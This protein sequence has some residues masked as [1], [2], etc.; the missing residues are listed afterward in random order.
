[1]FNL[2]ALI[3]IVSTLSLT[4]AP[5]I[6][7]AENIANVDEHTIVINE[8]QLNDDLNIYDFSMSIENNEINGNIEIFHGD[9]TY[10]YSELSYIVFNWSVNIEYFYDVQLQRFNG[11]NVWGWLEN[12]NREEKCFYN[13]DLNLNMLNGRQYSTLQTNLLWNFGV[14]EGNDW[15]AY[16][17]DING[18]EVENLLWSE[19]YPDTSVLDLDYSPFEDYYYIGYYNTWQFHDLYRQIDT[20]N[21]IYGI[22][23]SDSY[24]SGYNSGYNIGYNEGY[25]LG[26]TI[27]VENVAT[28]K[29]QEGY[30]KGYDDGYHS[31]V[32]EGLSVQNILYSII[33][34]P[35]TI[36]KQ[37]FDFDI[38]GIN[39]G[40]LIQTALVIG[41]VVFAIGMFKKG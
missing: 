6:V 11:A 8:Q 26:Y 23:N 4:S 10:Q 33:T 7:C 21:T 24:A 13:L 16:I 34:M 29:Y 15:F 19:Y 14:F 20:L 25:D 9:N 30:T 12:V 32:G 31:N 37:G 28:Q 35:S 1:M 17:E 40:N 38:L 39:V 27:N 3:G 18:E 36:I 5:A 22:S 2:G 41:L